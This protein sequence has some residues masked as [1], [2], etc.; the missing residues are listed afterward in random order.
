ML[1][2]KTH[3]HNYLLEKNEKVTRTNNI[4]RH[5]YSILFSYRTYRKSM[6]IRI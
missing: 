6:N 4:N 5:S 1:Y 2:N 3:N